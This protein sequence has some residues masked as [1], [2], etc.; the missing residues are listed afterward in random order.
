MPD[1]QGVSNHLRSN[2][3]SHVIPIDRDQ[4]NKSPREFLKLSSCFTSVKLSNTRHIRLSTGIPDRTRG[5]RHVPGICFEFWGSDVSLYVGKW[6]REAKHLVLQRGER[7]TRFTFW[8][9]QESNPTNNKR[10]NTGRITSIQVETTHKE[11]KLCLADETDM[12]A[13]S[14]IE[15][16]FEELVSILNSTL[17]SFLTLP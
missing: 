5:S 13:Y 9:A 15:N 12:F 8:Q 1:L 2:P 10:E 6:F 14:F 7:I 4:L 16:S 17:Q 11:V 3:P